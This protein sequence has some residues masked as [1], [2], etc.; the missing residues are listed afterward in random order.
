MFSNLYQTHYQDVDLCLKVLK[1]GLSCIINPVCKLIHHESKS[2]GNSY[3]LIDRMLLIDS[4]DLEINLGDKYYSKNHC[5]KKL[6]YS[7]I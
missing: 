1:K 2:R 5:I 7:E 4:W 3:D 6:D